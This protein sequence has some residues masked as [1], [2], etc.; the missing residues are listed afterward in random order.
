MILKGSQRSGG[1]QLA[2]HLLKTDENEHVE[3]HELRGFLS[4]DL[5]GAFQEAHAVSKGTRAKQYLFSL[6]LN[7]PQEEQVPIEVFE[8]AI[9]Q[10]EQRLGL[11]DQPRAIVF[12]EK[13]G[14][15]HAHAVW[16]RI[17]SQEMKAINLPHFKRK[18]NDIAKEMYLEHGWDMPNGFKTDR[19]PD[20]LNFDQE[21][22]QQAN[23]CGQDA[24]AIKQAFQECWRISDSPKAYIQALQSR[25]LYVARGD[26]RGHVAVD[27]QG[28]VH[29]IAK[30]TGLKAKEV[31]QRLGDPDTFPSIEEVK[32]QIAELAAN[33]KRK[34]LA[35]AKQHQEEK[36][37]SLEFQKAE[38][39]GRQR[40]E[41]DEL[42]R[43]Q[44]ERWNREAK[45][46]ADRLAKGLKGVWHR[47]T[48]KYARVRRQN[49][50]ETLLA[51]QRDRTEK[52]ALIF[53]HIEERQE[54]QRKV[55][56]QKNTYSVAAAQLRAEIAGFGVAKPKAQL[57]LQE[58][59]RREAKK[60]RLTKDKD[61]DHGPDFEPEI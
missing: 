60:R 42:T 21:E 6:S 44:E 30:R 32:K 52:D 50:R 49:E 14:R 4:D 56:D 47:L 24:K 10:I 40:R 35:Q 1:L 43:K 55:L 23:R 3:I 51:L 34:Q 31:R 53:R 17:D 16:S 39:V 2:S 5:H 57:S 46:R 18:L 8:A 29:S 37:A 27:L 26:R 58:E 54:L 41:R 12:H 25:G 7:P 61:Q 28:E 19:K 11:D 38:L 15:R 33:A 13:E 59:F 48:G 22:W 36:S 20:S 45:E 9:D